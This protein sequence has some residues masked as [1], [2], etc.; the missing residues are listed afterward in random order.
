M[1][2]AGAMG[3]AL[4]FLVLIIIT[5]Y[6]YWFSIRNEQIESFKRSFSQTP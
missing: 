2:G 3:S 4:H 6:T 5:S 1:I